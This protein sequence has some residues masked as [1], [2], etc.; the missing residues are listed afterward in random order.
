MAL[1]GLGEVMVRPM[2]CYGPWM[3]RDR[4][5]FQ[6]LF[7]YGVFVLGRWPRLKC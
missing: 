6:P 5:G 7:V 1:T 2:I 3:G 4:A